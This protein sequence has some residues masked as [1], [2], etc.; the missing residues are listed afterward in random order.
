MKV[1]RSKNKNCDKLGISLFSVN[2]QV[3]GGG[4]L[5]TFNS[6]VGIGIVRLGIN[7]CDCQKEKFVKLRN[8]MD[9]A[10]GHISEMDTA[11]EQVE[12]IAQKWDRKVV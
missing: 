2:L 6:S 1:N 12:E 8:R 4:L 9:T 3:G 11:L 5:K 10:D 7:E